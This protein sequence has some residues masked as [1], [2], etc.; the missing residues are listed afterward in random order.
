ML[1]LHLECGALRSS[2]PSLFRQQFLRTQSKTSGFAGKKRLRH[3]H[4]QQIIPLS[5]ICNLPNPVHC[6]LQHVY[7]TNTTSKNRQQLT[8]FHITIPCTSILSGFS[9]S[10]D[11]FWHNHRPERT[12]VPI[13]PARPPQQAVAAQT[14][15]TA[16]EP[17][18][19]LA[20]GHDKHCSVRSIHGM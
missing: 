16:L 9:P 7:I 1:L 13:E 10:V 2:K 12:T 19:K 15:L 11:R 3:G 6:Y 4:T 5:T 14:V 8:F 18:V 17:H 20:R